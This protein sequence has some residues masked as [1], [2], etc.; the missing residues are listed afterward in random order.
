MIRGLVIRPGREPDRAALGALVADAFAQAAKADLVEAIVRD[1]D[2][3][4]TGRSVRA[5]AFAGL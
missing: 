1:S 5:R 4:R 3:P 2:A